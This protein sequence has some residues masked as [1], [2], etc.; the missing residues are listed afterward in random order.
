MII[1]VTKKREVIEVA[2]TD[3]KWT[4]GTD[5]ASIERML[6]A[7]RNSIL[8][9]K[10]LSDAQR[11]AVDEAD[12]DALTDEVVALQKGVISTVIGEQG[13][14]DILAYMGDGE[15][16][17]PR[18]HTVTIGDVMAALS[19]WVHRHCAS[20]GIQDADAYFERTKHER[21]TP[22]ESAEK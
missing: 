11:E 17:D 6:N 13:Y 21:P 18:E 15:P 5:D 14:E 2:G 16:V 12:A 4:V 9:A 10:S 8:R 19:V 22:C 20:S 7:I 1:E 3:L